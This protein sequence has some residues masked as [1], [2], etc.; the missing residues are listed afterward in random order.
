MC[1]RHSCFQTLLATAM[2]FEHIQSDIHMLWLWEWPVAHAPLL[3]YRYRFNLTCMYCDYENDHDLWH[4]QK[5]CWW[6]GTGRFSFLT[7]RNKISMK[8]LRERKEESE[9]NERLQQKQE[10]KKITNAM[11]VFLPFPLKPRTPQS[12]SFPGFSFNLL[13]ERRFFKSIWSCDNCWDG[14]MSA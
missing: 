3:F 5:L 4:T 1:I 9:W 8:G 10:Q 13:F 14:V 12:L 7:W 2:I 6:D 11:S